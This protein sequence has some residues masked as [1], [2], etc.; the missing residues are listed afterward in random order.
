LSARTTEF[1]IDVHTLT[2]PSS[3]AD[4]TRRPSTEMAAEYTA[5][6]CPRNTPAAR[7]L[8]LESSSALAIT[9]DRVATDEAPPP[10]R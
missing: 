5:P 8:S 10:N 7:F 9:N 1:V 6:E 4:A 3:D 2:D